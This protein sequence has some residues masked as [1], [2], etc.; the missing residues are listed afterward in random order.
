MKADELPP[1]Y[2]AQVKRRALA[3]GLPLDAYERSAEGAWLMAKL[4]LCALGWALVPRRWRRDLGTR[5]NE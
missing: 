5:G 3:A 4:A 2:A 1:I